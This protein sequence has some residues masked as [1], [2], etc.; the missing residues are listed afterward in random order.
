MREKFIWTESAKECYYRHKQGLTCENCPIF[1]KLESLERC[2]LIVQVLQIFAVRG[3]PTDTEYHAKDGFKKCYRCKEILPVE[4]FNK[5]KCNKADG[6]DNYCK[7]CRTEYVR[8]IKERRK[9]GLTRKITRKETF[10]N[11]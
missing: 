11:W 4:Y 10:L 6:L 1:P 2:E 7:E 5:N 3:E 9:R 8:Q